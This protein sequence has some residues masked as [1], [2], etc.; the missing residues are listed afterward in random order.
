MNIRYIV[1]TV[2]ALFGTSIKAQNQLQRICVISDTHIMAPS[3]LKQDGKAFQDYLAADRKLLKESPELMDSAVAR[4]RQAR[5]QALLITGDLTKDGEQVSHRYLVDHYLKP[6]RQQGIRIFVIPG[7]HDINNPHAV[8]FKGDNTER[9]STVSAQ[10]FANI[11]HDYGF[12]EA[13]ARDTASL[14]YVAQLTPAIRLIAIDACKYY[15]NDFD[16]NTCVTS[17]RI[18]PATLAFITRAVADAKAHGCKVLA[19]MHH[20]MAPHFRMQDLVLSEYLVDDFDVLARRFSE[21]GIKV[22]FSGHFHSQDIAR[23]GDLTDVETGSVVSYPHPVRTI[24]ISA[25]SLY[26]RTSDITSLAS[27]QQGE[28]LQQKSRRFAASAAAHM[29]DGMIPAGASPQMKAAIE[30][31]AAQAYTLH[32]GG[33]EQA[34]EAFLQALRTFVAIGSKSYPKEARICG[35]IARYLSEDILPKDNN[36]NLAY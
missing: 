36:V 32:L 16:K 4:I 27:M 26:I 23:E 7:N 18:K 15:E 25:D 1:I 28:T 19:M 13:I 10:E 31:L 6:L 2:L 9:A 21:M 20:G 17:G 12:G 30:Q 3:L 11:Y 35:L 24:D 33:D 8:V 29:V 34:P 22:V 14:T 5:P